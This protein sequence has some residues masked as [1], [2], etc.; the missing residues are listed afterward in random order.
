[1]YHR[2]Y[3]WKKQRI[4]FGFTWTGLLQRKRRAK[5]TTQERHSHATMSIRNYSA[6]ARDD[7]DARYRCH[8]YIY[9]ILS[10]INTFTFHTITFLCSK[11][12]ESRCITQHILENYSIVNISLM[13][14][15]QLIAIEGVPAS[16]APFFIYFFYRI[17][18]S[19]IRSS[20]S[21]LFS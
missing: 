9:I 19:I 21:F 18:D 14:L 16:L 4:S 17:N 2:N 15:K 11:I 7:T 3:I 12:N 6:G 10:Y 13:K 1:M 5:S 20:F 8:T